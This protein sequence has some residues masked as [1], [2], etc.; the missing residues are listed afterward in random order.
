MISFMRS[1]TGS[2]PFAILDTELHLSAGASR[3]YNYNTGQRAER[4]AAHQAAGET[5]PKHERPDPV[6]L[7]R[8]GQGSQY[9]S[10]W[11]VML[12]WQWMGILANGRN[13]ELPLAVRDQGSPAAVPAGISGKPICFLLQPGSSAAC[14]SAAARHA[15]ASLFSASGSFPCP[16]CRPCRPLCAPLFA[17]GS[18]AGILQQPV[19]T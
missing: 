14:P 12:E 7:P 11:P 5:D 18:C 1:F 15:H 8:E 19:T 6:M 16:S 2:P 10:I 4:V 9:R 3:F 17:P 13:A